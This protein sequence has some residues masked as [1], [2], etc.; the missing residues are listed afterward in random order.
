MRSVRW[1]GLALLVGVGPVRGQ[2]VTS[3]DVQ[4]LVDKAIAYLKTTQNEN[5]SFAPKLGGPG[6]T[7]L[8]V[9]G[10]I[11]NG[12]SP[13]DPLVAKSLKYLESQVQKDGGIYNKA[14]ANYATSVSMFAF[15]E[16]NTNGQYDGVL[17]NGREFLKTMQ[18]MD[19]ALTPTHG[20]ASYDGKGNPDLSNTAFNIEALLAAGLSKDDPA[21]KRAIVY[22]GRVQNL[23]G[24]ANTLDF[25]KKATKDDE[26]GLTYKQDVSDKNPYATPA[27]G[28]RSL[29][30]MTYSGLKSFLY[31]GIS[32]DDPRVKGAVGWIR[33]HYTLAEN[34]GMG[35]AGLYYYY[36]TF[37]KA[38]D[39]LGEEQFV[40]AAGTK[41]AWRKELFD[42][43]KAKQKA[44]GGWVND[45]ERTFGE[46]NAD[47]ATAFALLSLSYC[48]K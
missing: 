11:K 5:G 6:V 44:D 4:P 10:L 15:K 1:L 32:K 26:G 14:L 16:A 29:G 42:T 36:H 43:L 45:G 20:G 34:P 35:K 22:V 33:R 40:D 17:K 18:N 38:M 47:L 2:D 24:E 48:K 19:D 9:A 8:V 28:L 41:H 30:A 31:A 21:I 7:A 37:G 46:S 12:V 25:A 3:K 23:P 13:Q 39:A 27:G